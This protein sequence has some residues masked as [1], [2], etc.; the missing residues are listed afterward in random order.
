MKKAAAKPVGRTNAWWHAAHRMPAT[1][2]AELERRRERN[3]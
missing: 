3:A 2:V 1:V